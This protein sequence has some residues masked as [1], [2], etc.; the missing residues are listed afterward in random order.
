[1]RSR[2]VLQLP[3]TIKRHAC[4][5]ISSIVLFSAWLRDAGSS[6]CLLVSCDRLQLSLTV[7]CE[8]W[9]SQL[10]SLCPCPKPSLKRWP[11]KPRPKHPNSPITGYNN[12][13]SNFHVKL[14][15]I[16]VEP[17]S[18]YKSNMGIWYI[19]KLLMNNMGKIKL[20][21]LHDIVSNFSGI[22]SSAM[23]KHSA[24]S[25]RRHLG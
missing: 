7:H 6:L 21:R 8:C 19:K 4:L 20:L 18:W 17:A 14:N 15:T 9:S 5:L 25:R 24:A 11:A 3:P 10:A 23:S 13:Q 2:Q 22:L 16:E 1:M 12:G